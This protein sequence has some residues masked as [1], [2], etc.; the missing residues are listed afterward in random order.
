MKRDTWIPIVAVGLALW[1]LGKPQRTCRR[2]WLET[3]LALDRCPSGKIR[4]TADLRVD[5]LRRGEPG[6]VHVGATAYYTVADADAAQAAPITEFE[7]I[8][9]S[10]VDAKGHATPITVDGWHAGSAR[11]KVPEVTDGDYKLHAAYAT[12]LGKGELD[13][14]V[15]FYTP[16]R[17]HVI[18]DRPLYEPG[19]LVH[20]R[21][22]VLR[23]RDLSPID[24]RPGTWIVKDPAG[25]VL[26]EEKAPAADWGVVA[27]TFPLDHGAPTGQWHVAWQSNDAIDDVP[28][29]V[30]PFTL[31]RFRVDTSPGKPFYQ[32]GDTPAI[33]GA[34]VYSSGA[35]VAG[36]RL[37]LQWQITGDWPPPTDWQQNLLPKQAVA[38]ANGRFELTL[39]KV[40]DDLQGQVTI[41]ASISAID[42][43]GDRVAATSR[44]LLSKDGIAVSAVTELGDGLVAGFNNRMYLRVT[45]PDGRA[46]PGAKIK[47]KRAWQANDNG[48]DAELDE[49]GVGSLQLDPG[50]PVNVVIPALPY[51]PAPRAPIVSRG[52]AEELIA[53]EGA[54]LVDQEE[55]DRWLAPLAAC[56]KWVGAAG[57]SDGD[58]D[59]SGGVRVALRVDA[60][61]AIVTAG[62]G[63]SPLDRCVL[64]VVRQHR[65]PGG[66]ERMYAISFNFGDPDLPHVTATVEAALETPEGLSNQ[67][68]SLAN[69]ARDCVPETAEGELPMALVWRT[70]AGAKDVE[71]GGWLRDPHGTTGAALGC[72]QSRIAGRITLAENQ[73]RDL[74]GLVRFSVEPPQRVRQERPQPTT[75]LGY[76]LVVATDTASTK[77][78][79]VPGEIPML[80]MR[81]EPVLARPGDAVTAQLIRGPAFAGELPKELVLTCLK[82]HGKAPLGEDH[83]AKLAIPA[84]TEG[85]CE[86]AGGGVRGLVYVRPAAELAVTVQTQDHYKPGERAELHIKTLLGGKGGKAAVGL[87]GVDESLG[88]LVPLPGPDDLGRVR[89]K[90]ETGSPAFGM[91]DGQALA[92]GRIRGANAAAATV[93]RVTAVPPP[94]ALDAVVSA[95]IESHFDPVEELTDHFYNV[96]AELHAQTRAWEATAPKS[97]KMH[98]VTMARLW[99]Q[100]LAACRARHERTDDAYGRDLRLATLPADL[101]ALTDPRAVVV[102]GTRLP[103]DVENWPAWVAK[104]NP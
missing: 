29:T 17:V 99:K 33:R 28:F 64:G 54:P 72:I 70:R 22:V 94:P 96:L 93:L 104:E 42:P 98:P 34:V 68:Q 41:A 75:M 67:L 59:A 38:A 13:L 101:I 5:G 37:D 71:L 82:S 8:A 1:G 46:L 23:A 61:G 26:L 66:S 76:E 31:P 16:A 74:L 103:E 24:G 83:T 53:G 89:P 62:G 87:I 55:F 35:P 6:M 18:T 90:V 7:S 50:A 84:G 58:S 77:L 32:P 91:L 78:R 21:A 60:G 19:N 43:A 3:G 48:I 52:D 49:D 12:R 11:F 15:P 39:P 9:L 73:T 81:V 10:L 97:E 40:P 86:V 25:E 27:G 80:R 79:V 85:W 57:A 69:G 95:R 44:V 65:L 14:P 4:Q 100:A 20:F 102:L 45:T 63:A 2:T 47:V 51:R 36:A 56:A 88:Q 30:E 92:L